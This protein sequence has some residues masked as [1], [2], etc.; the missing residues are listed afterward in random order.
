MRLL[1][2]LCLH[3]LLVLRLLRG[4][5]PGDVNGTALRRLHAEAL[6][7]TEGASREE[8][9]KAATILE[10]V[11]S[12]LRQRCGA[13]H[14]DTVEALTELD[15]ARMTLAARVAALERVSAEL[16]ARVARLYGAEASRHLA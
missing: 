16:D 14:P 1:L 13:G 11:L 7:K 3:S 15:R 4:I 9:F 2:L 6:Y 12:G 8:V 10:D 5:D